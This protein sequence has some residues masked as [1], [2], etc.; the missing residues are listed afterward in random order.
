MARTQ[1]RPSV[2]QG[3][4]AD[5]GVAGAAGLGAG[6]RVSGLSESD[7]KFIREIHS[8]R[9]LDGSPF[10]LDELQFM[11]AENVRFQEQALRELGPGSSMVG[12]YRE[13]IAA[14]DERITEAKSP[15][16][17]AI[18]GLNTVLVDPNA[19]EKDRRDKIAAALG[20]IREG[21]KAGKDDDPRTPEVFDL[22]GKLVKQDAKEKQAALKELVDKEK[23][24]SGAVSEDE[25]RDAIL[26][27]MGIVRQESL[28]GI[29]DD[30][31]G[32]ASGLGHVVESLNLVADRRV[33]NLKDL[34]AKEKRAPG[35]VSEQQFAKLVK[36]VLGDERTKE[37]LGISD[38]LGNGMGPVIEVLKLLL[39]RRRDAID[40]L[41]KKQSTQG[42]RVSNAQINQAISDY[43]VAKEQ[44]IM[45]GLSVPNAPDL[46]DQDPKVESPPR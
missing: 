14:Y 10:S 17:N 1:N 44:A 26:K 43:N 3:V 31:S 36:A 13:V 2:P 22:V 45:F 20:V 37:L 33:A 5:P 15:I 39:Q 27:V 6:V 41:F 29:D 19:T 30:S 23:R 32:T 11:R 46:L 42:S 28:L 24:S 4:T 8:A 16:G 34:I 9:H 40:G 21:Q 18:N 38:S 25:F 12:F 35:S 7:R